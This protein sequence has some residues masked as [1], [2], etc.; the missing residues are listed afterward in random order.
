MK[1]YGVIVRATVTKTVF[2]EAENE[3]DAIELAHEQFNILCDG[4]E[5]DYNQETISFEEV[6]S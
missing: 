3:D 6:K 5:E 4:I 1:E 2:V